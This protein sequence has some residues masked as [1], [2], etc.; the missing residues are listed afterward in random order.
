MYKTSS[1]K[2]Q[3]P[4]N[5]DTGPVWRLLTTSTSSHNVCGRGNIQREFLEQKGATLV[6][7][8]QRQQAEGLLLNLQ[9]KY[10]AFQMP[11]INMKGG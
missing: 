2:I 3:T 8:L 7:K 5:R 1:G 6:I 10:T 11:A 9:G 4:R